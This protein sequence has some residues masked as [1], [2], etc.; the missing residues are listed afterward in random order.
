MCH[1]VGLLDHDDVG[2]PLR[3]INFPDESSSQKL[4]YLFHNSLV[5]FKS[6]N[7]SFLLD[8]LLGGVEI[9]LMLY[10]F[11][12]YPRHIFMSLGEDIH[13]LLEELHNLALQGGVK[14]YPHFCYFGRV[15]FY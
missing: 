12:F 5:P 2:Q 15:P 1:F 13:V 10:H 4:F 14:S 7:S 8:G 6:E 9:Q 3:I 11:I